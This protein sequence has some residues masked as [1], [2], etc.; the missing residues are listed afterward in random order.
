MTVLPKYCHNMGEQAEE[1]LEPPDELVAQPGMGHDFI[2]QSTTTTIHSAEITEHLGCHEPH[3][4]WAW[5]HASSPD[6]S[7]LGT[8][9]RW[10]STLWLAGFHRW[11]TY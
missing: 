10:P 11:L 6:L 7:D 8:T 2:L 5:R 4:T 1:L 9:S 3:W